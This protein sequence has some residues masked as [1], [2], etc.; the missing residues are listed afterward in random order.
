MTSPPP[1]WP[2]TLPPPRDPAGPYRICLVCLGN[3]CRSPMAEAVLRAGLDRAGL[4]GAVAVDS[5]GTG[6]WHI[7]N[8]MDS[9]ARAELASRGYDGS[10][11]RARQVAPSWLAGRDLVL[12][13]D[14]QNLAD[15]RAMA[16]DDPAGRDR[17][18]LLRSF[19]QRS[20]PDA[21]VPDPY[22]G[23]GASFGMVLDLI[24]AAAGGLAELLSAALAGQRPTRPGAGR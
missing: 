19:D 24:E 3:I 2:D 22:Y 14:G 17:I 12:A 21:E 9:R 11:H 4:G 10:P 13:M 1:A 6:D 18:R 15:L 7:G 16:G 5:A 23:E 8:R 20:G